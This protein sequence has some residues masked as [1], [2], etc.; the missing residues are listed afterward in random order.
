MVWGCSCNNKIGPLVLIEGTLNSDRYIELLKEYLIPF[1]NNLG[2]E[3][4]IFQDDNTPVMLQKKLKLG[5]MKIKLNFFHGLYKVLTLIQLKICGIYWKERSLNNRSV[6]NEAFSHIF[7][8]NEAMSQYFIK[9]N[10]RGKKRRMEGSEIQLLRNGLIKEL[11]FVVNN[12]D[13]V[14][15]KIITKFSIL[16]NVK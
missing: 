12:S 13:T 8:P 7:N 5:K 6:N 4:H 2:I 1:L 10:T 3:N 14:D 11:T 9:P 16:E 15:I